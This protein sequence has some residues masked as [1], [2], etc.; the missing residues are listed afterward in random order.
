MRRTGSLQSLKLMPYACL[1]GIMRPRSRRSGAGCRG[2]QLTSTQDGCNKMVVMTV[3]IVR[4]ALSPRAD[5]YL[6]N[7]H[8]ATALGAASSRHNIVTTTQK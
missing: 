3:R 4:D 2:G 8:Y 1:I 6:I 7:R 5:R